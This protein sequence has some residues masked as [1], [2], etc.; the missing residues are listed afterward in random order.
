MEITGKL[1]QKNEVRKITET[2]SVQEIIADCGYM[3]QMQEWK[4]NI[5]KFQISNAN[6]EEISKVPDDSVLKFYFFP[7]GRW[8]DKKDN[9][10]KDVAVN[11]DISKF[12]VLKLAEQE[13]KATETQNND[14][15]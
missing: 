7:K 2:F 12:E 4:E 14:L 13:Q 11:L 15:V 5:I 10:G 8:F 9:S 6:I 1:L 3:N